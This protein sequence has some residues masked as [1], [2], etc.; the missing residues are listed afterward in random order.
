MGL[1][2]TTDERGVRVWRDDRYGFPKYSVSISKK[3]EDGQYDH[4]YIDVCFHKG[5]ELENKTDIQIIEAF[6]T[7][8]VGKDGKKYISWFIKDYER[9]D[10]APKVNNTK[11]FEGVN[12]PVDLEEDEVPFN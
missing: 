1:T 6:P 12:F 3:L 5:V 4:A 7:F 8:N 11:G 2:L 9:M 10:G